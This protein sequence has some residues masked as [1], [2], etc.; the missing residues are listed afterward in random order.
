[1]IFEVPISYLDKPLV[2]HKD[3]DYWI[4]KFVESLS[5]TAPSYNKEP[6]AIINGKV[7]A[8]KPI[9]VFYFSNPSDFEIVSAIKPLY[10][11]QSSSYG[12]WVMENSVT[13]PT[14]TRLYDVPALL[15]H[16][17]VQA[18]FTEKKLCEYYLRW[19]TN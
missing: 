16:Y 9:R 4:S 17:Y 11:W 12:S 6:Y 14:W 10:E 19:G 13:I 15:F 7:E 2:Y 1:L 5:E 3:K 8:V 18:R